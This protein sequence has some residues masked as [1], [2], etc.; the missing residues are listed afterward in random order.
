DCIYTEHILLSSILYKD[1]SI[2]VFLRGNVSMPSIL[3]TL[4]RSMDINLIVTNLKN[5]PK[6]PTR[7]GNSTQTELPKNLS[8]LGVDFTQRARENKIDPIIGRKEEIERIIEILC[9][10]TKNNPV[11]IG[12]PGV[13]K[14]AVVEGLA[15]EVVAGNVPELLKD[16]IIFSLDIGSLVA[17]TKYRGELEQRLKNA[18]DTIIAQGN[19]IVFI[20]EMHTLAQAGGKEGEVTP[21]DMLKPYL[22]RGELQTI[23]ATTTDEYRK[24]IEKD[25]ALER[26]FQPIIVNPP[27]VEQTI[28]ILKGIRP[29]YEE[30]HKIKITDDAIVSAATLSDRYISD[31]FL[32]DKAIDLID[33]AASRAKVSGN[34]V[35]PEVK[36]LEEKIALLQKNINIVVDRDDY[37]KAA[38]YKKLRDDTQAQLDAKRKEWK[39]SSSTEIGAEEIAE[40]V[41][42]WTK[43]P[44]TKLTETELERLNN[45]ESILHER[46]VG[47]DMAVASVSK[48]IRRAR[49]GLKDPKRP[50]GTFLFL[51]PTGVGKT[52]L[53]KALASAM[54]D[55]ENNIIRI[56]MSEYMEGHSVSKLIGAPP[57]YVGFDDGGQLTE[58]VRRKPYSVV[59]FD[60]IEK[61][62]PDVYNILLQL[63]DEGRLTD[64]Q[65]RLVSF[66][67][68]I[69]IMTSNVGVNELK[70][71]RSI[72]FNSSQQMVDDN[73]EQILSNA[74]KRHFRPEFLNRID[75]ICYFKHLTEENIKK[76]ADVMMV[77]VT[78]KLTDRNI[79]L[80]YTPAIVEY[81]IKNGYD[82][83]YGARPLRRIIEQTIEDALAEAL[84]TG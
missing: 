82:P 24:F 54:F 67:N 75:V 71:K 15:R 9:R 32:P 22:A 57:G 4:N 39:L 18:I 65:G 21:S 11:L 70:V 61:A 13:G 44:I 28:E 26:R 77:K 17:G 12:E 68:T 20:D 27:T 78:K 40:V 16:K 23:G 29:N 5:L 83:E 62:H 52:E 80:R 46:V 66:K 42:K 43:I 84:L 10:K 1:S 37:D 47:Q 63:L 49:A 79:S 81:V 31:R 25:K 14:S 8:D 45:L 7:S 73:E 41:S 51:G 38:E 72:G 53:T 50:I 55:D 36:E 2:Q 76:I 34:R 58:Q 64:S 48:A 30:F 56:D 35:P 19:I 3:N 60:E 6:N 33:E 74:L 59:L 69:V